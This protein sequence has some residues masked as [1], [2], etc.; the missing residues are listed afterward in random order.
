VLAVGGA[1]G[2]KLT[3]VVTVGRGS[4]FS[5]AVLGDGSLVAWGLNNV[6]QLGN[7]TNAGVAVAPCTAV[8]GDPLV[9]CVPYPTVVSGVK[10]AKSVSAGLS[11]VLVTIGPG[12]TPIPTS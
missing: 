1:G 5:L 10:G 11:H 3:N 9:S 8:S 4:G 12:G 2:S 7:G 6:G